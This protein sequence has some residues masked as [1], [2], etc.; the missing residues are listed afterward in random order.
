[1]TRDVQL[2]QDL[3]SRVPAFGGLYDAHVFNNDGVLP[4]VIF[5]EITQDT[6]RS[7][8][9]AD[10]AP[11]WRETLRFLEEQMGPE[12]PEI[13]TVIVTSFLFALPWPHKAGYGIVQ[14]LGPRLA[15][16]FAKIRPSG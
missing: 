11:D 2:V 12:I 16:A 7:H 5:W 6:V 13:N 14:E 3:V 8:L 10:D 15:K 9:G 4:H 1:M